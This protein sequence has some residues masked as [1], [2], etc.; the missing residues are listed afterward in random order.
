MCKLARACQGTALRGQKEFPLGLAI[1]E[2]PKHAF[3]L[4]ILLLGKFTQSIGSIIASQ[5]KLAKFEC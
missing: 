5:M 3:S 4:T 2:Q 1:G